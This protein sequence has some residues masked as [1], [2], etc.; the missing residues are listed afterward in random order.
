M[1]ADWSTG[2]A[3][4][5]GFTQRAR[6]AGGDVEYT[7]ARA[8]G[9]IYRGGVWAFIGRRAETAGGAQQVGRRRK[10]RR[11]ESNERVHVHALRGVA[12]GASQARARLTR[13]VKTLKSGGGADEIDR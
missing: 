2:R 3:G 5:R 13:R 7:S 6:Q 9:G 12:E 1:Q 8:R 10:Q 11:R 4:G